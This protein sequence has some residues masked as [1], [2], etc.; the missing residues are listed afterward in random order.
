MTKIIVLLF[1]LL[2]GCAAQMR[3]GLHADFHNTCGYPVQVTVRSYSNLKDNPENSKLNQYVDSGKV[4]RVLSIISF[5]D[6]AGID[7]PG[8]Y[9]LEI[10]G[11][12]KVRGVDKAKFIKILKQA[13][14]VKIGNATYI[15]TITDPSLCP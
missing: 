4:V 10:S 13:S 1:L 11:N 14:H 6:D 12:S 3:Y 9:Y 5:D 2:S 15:W 7:T 8:D